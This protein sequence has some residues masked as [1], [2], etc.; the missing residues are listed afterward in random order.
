MAHMGA[1]RVIDL[2][3]RRFYWPGMA[4][5]I[6]NFVQ[7]RCRCIVNKPPNVIETAAME[8]IVTTH[9]FELIQIDFMHLDKCK[10]S[11]QYAMVVTDNFTKFCQIYGT[12]SKST[13]AAADK[14]FNNFIVQFGF[15]ERIH[16][17][18]G[19]EFTSKLFREIQRL[20][21][22]EASTTTP[23]HPQGNGQTERMNRTVCTMLKTLGEQAKKDWRNQLPKLAFAY[24][25]TIHKSTGFSP[26]YLMFGREARLPLD[27]MFQEVA[28]DDAKVQNQE[29]QKFVKDWH[30]SMKEAMELARANMDKAA[31][32]N[33]RYHDKKAKI[34][35]VNVGDKVL[36]RNYR[37]KGGTGK[38]K[39][40]WEE[41]IFVVTEKR[42]G[43]PVYKVKNIKKEKDVRVVHRNKIMK[44][45][46]LP[47]D[48]FDEPQEPKKS[49]KVVAKK[50][51]EK[52]ANRKEQP[53]PTQQIEESRETEETVQSD[54]E[55]EDL[56]E[57][58]I[59]MDQV[60][61]RDVED[62]HLVTNDAATQ[63]ELDS[64]L[65]STLGLETSGVLSEENTED[66]TL[67]YDEE[68]EE[69]EVTVAYDQDVE[70]PETESAE[71]TLDD[72]AE[73]RELEDLVEDSIG[74][75]DSDG[76]QGNDTLVDSE[77]EES[78]SPDSS[79]EPEVRRSSRQRVPTTKFSY[80]TVGGN[81][82]RTALNR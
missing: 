74:D 62:V 63:I 17:D 73:L 47:L 29:H 18:Q 50:K 33:K 45:E 80:D 27:L 22:I 5:D 55:D 78:D 66:P 64:T 40:F 1:D 52:T 60:Q 26:M 53:E 51:S 31:D 37:E 34:V 79:P 19:G 10:G 43:L 12:R 11:F 67:A 36:V 82:T 39:S 28:V 72:S 9:P 15:P 23:Y 70:L 56:A 24:N 32:Y 7:T 75:E 65:D 8:T 21:K 57:L 2:A 42:D 46:E 61:S 71:N 6:K 49:K 16:S 44:C 59:T 30:T 20:A 76:S 58:A 69:E 68:I 41:A 3:Q 81:P 54:S 48:V 4:T 35:Q 77:A 25:S 13:K 14:L 38:L